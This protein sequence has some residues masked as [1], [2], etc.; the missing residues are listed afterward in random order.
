MATCKKS[1]APRYTPVWSSFLQIIYIYICRY[2]PGTLFQKLSFFFVY[3]YIPV[4][5]PVHFFPN[6]IYIYAGTP[7]VHSPKSCQHIIELRFVLFSAWL[8]PQDWIP[9]YTPGTST[10]WRGPAERSTGQ[11]G[12]RYTLPGTRYR[13][14]T[15]PPG[16]RSQP[17][18]LEQRLFACIYLFI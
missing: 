18:P 8:W 10:Y 15:P 1:F 4:H 17:V 12:P 14:G 9:R 7:P 2:T 16:T 6:R 11:I 5:L 3:I 13:P